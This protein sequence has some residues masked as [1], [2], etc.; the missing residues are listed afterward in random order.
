MPNADRVVLQ[1]FVEDFLVLE[2]TDEQGVGFNL[3]WRKG[4]GS[5]TITSNGLRR[6][7]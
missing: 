1:S 5:E 3:T 2:G 4:I 7:A 6:P